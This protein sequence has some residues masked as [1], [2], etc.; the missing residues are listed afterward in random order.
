MSHN[1]ITRHNLHCHILNIFSRGIS[2]LAIMVMILNLCRIIRTRTNDT[3]NASTDA[4]TRTATI[5][6][7]VT[8]R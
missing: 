7:T 8:R 3:S 4:R 1:D 5:I 6:G 2:A